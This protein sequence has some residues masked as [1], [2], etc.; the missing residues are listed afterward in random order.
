MNDT[1][2]RSAVV[3]KA[4]FARHQLLSAKDKLAPEERERDDMERDPCAY[5]IELVAAKGKSFFEHLPDGRVILGD[6]R[7][8]SLPQGIGDVPFVIDPPA[9]VQDVSSGWINL[10][11][12]R[13]A[14]MEFKSADAAHQFLEEET[15]QHAMQGEHV[16]F[17][18]AEHGCEADGSRDRHTV[19]A[20]RA[21][22]AEVVQ[23]PFYDV[24]S[25]VSMAGAL[26]VAP[27]GAFSMYEGDASAS[28]FTM[29]RLFSM[30]WDDGRV[31]LSGF[32][33]ACRPGRP[34]P[35]VCQNLFDNK[36]TQ[37]VPMASYV[38]DIDRAEVV[39][40]STGDLKDAPEMNDY[41][42]CDYPQ[43]FFPEGK[44][45]PG[46][47]VELYAHDV[48]A[49]GVVSGVTD[50]L[51]S[52]TVAEVSIEYPD[53]KWVVPPT[54]GG[55]PMVRVESFK[56]PKIWEAYERERGAGVSF[57]DSE[58]LKSAG[59]SALG[60]HFQGCKLGGVVVSPIYETSY[61]YRE[62]QAQ[63]GSDG[64]VLFSSDGVV[65]DADLTGVYN[66]DVASPDT[67]TPVLPPKSAGANA[68]MGL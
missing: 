37:C 44:V 22:C 45:E 8:A 68:A 34:E 21:A 7:F 28:N 30:A 18:L 46:A 39:Y 63:T 65:F 10:T 48:Y 29:T 60:A 12:D 11:C 31:T 67:L 26:E 43:V 61:I 59:E 15:W 2:E 66:R 57:V 13:T 9:Y 41:S 38:W 33:G 24:N 54:V 56:M 51:G 55:V 4:Q 27:P 1:V 49:R 58:Q 40:D 53:K 19:D 5:V 25:V 23:A 62:T 3:P 36:L 6:D 16:T 64:H 17:P 47:I 35:A 42:S 50:A 20:A 14:A 32:S 52:T